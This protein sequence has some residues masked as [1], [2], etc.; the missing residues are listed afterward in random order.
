MQRSPQWRTTRSP[1]AAALGRRGRLACVALLA[2]ACL[3]PM[4]ASA[5]YNQDVQGTNPGDNLNNPWQESLVTDIGVIQKLNDTIPTDLPLI[6]EQ[7]N[8]VNLAD[9]YKAGRPVVLN[10]GYNRCPV[11]CGL[12][13]KQL[14]DTVGDTG[15]DMG[16][17]YVILNISIDPNETP[18]HSR[19][20]RED[21]EAMLKKNGAAFDADGWRFLTADQQTIDTLT[22]AVGFQYFYIPPQNE[23]GHPSMIVLTTGDAT[24]SR[25]LTG[26]T[27]DS[28]TLRLSLVEASEGKVGSILDQAFL[29]CFRW[30][31][32]A[33]NYAATAKFIMM[34][35]G[36]VTMLAI[37][38]GLLTLF[39]YERRRQTI[40]CHRD[41]HDTPHETNG[42][43]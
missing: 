26:T 14:A 1:L 6:D 35:G 42:S 41:D 18:E 13:L 17:D 7:G 39:A 38:G 9:F 34:T 2:G 24:I 5:R 29:T 16:E 12:M 30:D 32:E 19:K 23:F 10:L 25:Y 31:P 22:D 40:L 21:A 15:L 37:G 33:N 36:V 43:A 11:V 3:M 20:T 28:K 27:Y 8:A 4:P